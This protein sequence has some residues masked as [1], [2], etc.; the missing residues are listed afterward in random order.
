[1]GKIHNLLDRRPYCAY[2]MPMGPAESVRK[3]L[4]FWSGLGCQA[5]PYDIDAELRPAGWTGVELRGGSSGKD[6]MKSFL[7]D[8]DSVLGILNLS[9]RFRRWLP[10]EF[11]LGIAAPL[12]GSGPGGTELVCFQSG[13]DASGADL[14]RPGEYVEYQLAE[15]GKALGAEGLLLAPARPFR[16]R[17]L[18]E[19]HPLG[20][21]P[22]L[23]AR[24][25]AKKTLKQRKRRG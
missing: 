15:L 24:N 17:D 13:L 21:V 1:M 23:T 6:F 11:A 9:K 4:E 2:R 3:A 19:G 5:L 14:S 20:L 12:N 16:E 18:P 7:S 8:N 25:K 22:W 10:N